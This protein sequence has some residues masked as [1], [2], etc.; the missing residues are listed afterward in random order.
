MPIQVDRDLEFFPAM[1]KI[2]GKLNDLEKLTKKNKEK[3]DTLIMKVDYLIKQK[4][5]K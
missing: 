2:T 5:V 3:L 4:D 1:E